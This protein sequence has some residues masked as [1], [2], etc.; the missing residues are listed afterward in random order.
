MNDDQIVDTGTDE[1][2]EGSDAPEDESSFGDGAR[3]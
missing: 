1:G 3:A 2:L